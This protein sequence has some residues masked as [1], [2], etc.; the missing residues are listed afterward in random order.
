VTERIDIGG[1]TIELGN[2]DKVMFPDPGI[3][4]RQLADYHRRIG[5]VMLPHTRGRPVTMHRFPDGVDGT[6]FYQKDA[7]GYFPDWIATETVS[8][9]D[10]DVTHVVV[11][12][13]A[14][15]VYLADQACITPHVWLSTTDHLDRPDRLVFDLDP[16]KGADD[17][18]PVRFAALAIRDLLDELGLPSRIMTT[19]SSGFHVVVPLRASEPFDTVRGFARRCSDVLAG[20]HPD[21]LTV[22]QRIRA[23]SGR[24]FLD[25]LRNAYAQTTVAPYAVRALPGAPVATPIDWDELGATGPRSYTMENILRRLG[26]KDDPW[27]VDGL[28]AEDVRDATARLGQLD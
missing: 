25:Y 28:K 22:E 21:R 2:P 7:P 6:D 20:R 8:K 19:G 24:V 16:P 9:D 15:L 18:E 4:K 11:D 12:D 14:T 10:G 27:A 1:H 23:R 26:Q 5:A 3:T 17:P 13:V